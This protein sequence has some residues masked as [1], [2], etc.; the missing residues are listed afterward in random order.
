M[1]LLLN[2][3]PLLPSASQTQTP[4]GGGS[5]GGSA[6]GSPGGSAS[7][8][9]GD[10]VPGVSSSLQL[11]T[12][13]FM[14]GV[15]AV[16]RRQVQGGSC[17]SEG[18][19]PP[20]AGSADCPGLSFPTGT[21]E[22]IQAQLT[23]YGRPDNSPSFSGQTGYSGDPQGGNG[24]YCDPTT[25]AVAYQNTQFPHGTRVYIPRFQKY[26]A[27][28]DDCSSPQYPDFC[29]GTHLDLWIGDSPSDDGNGGKAV[30]D[31]EDALT[32][33]EEPIIIYPPPGEPVPNPGPIYQNGTCP[34]L[35]PL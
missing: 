10:P 31:C 27:R 22:T 33:N 5:P 26:F 9:P 12:C 3:C 7:G 19:T 8:S 13:D 25:Y 18:L 16:G 32:G 34:N 23:L 29:P 24:T 11:A 15:G 35:P 20:P 30:T 21:T 4:P 17:G 28:D 1:P 14:R 2:G 6:S